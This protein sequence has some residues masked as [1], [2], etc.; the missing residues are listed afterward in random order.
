[1]VHIPRTGGRAVQQVLDMEV[2]KGDKH[3]KVSWYKKKYPHYRMFTIIR[4]FRDRMKSARNHHKDDALFYKNNRYFL[5]DG[6]VYKIRYEYLEQDL[7]IFL[8][9]LGI[10]KVY[11]KGMGLGS[12]F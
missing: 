5:D 11:L 9:G 1:M 12:L 2:E 10:G 4:S 3:M 8:E 6:P 7:N